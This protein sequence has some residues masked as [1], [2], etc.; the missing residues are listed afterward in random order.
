MTT[1]EQ[2]RKAIED[3]ILAGDHNDV[4]LLESV[5]HPQFQNVQDG[6]FEQ[7][8]IFIFS[9]EEYKKLVETKRFGGSARTIDFVTINIS[10][11]IAHATLKLESEFLKFDSTV[12]LCK[13]DSRWMVIH[14][15]PAI[16]KK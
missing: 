16:E 5:L 13:V 3:F 4:T 6:F 8:G 14:N 10:G 7:K 1:Q 11:N 2:V 15:L 9:K 12:V